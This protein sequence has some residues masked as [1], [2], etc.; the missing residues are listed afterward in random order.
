MSSL[1][2][3]TKNYERAVAALRRGDPVEAQAIALGAEEAITL[4]APAS[5]LAGH[6]LNVLGAVKY[7]LG[8]YKGCIDY[9]ER[10]SN[11]YN[12]LGMAEGEFAT[13][14][15]IASALRAMG[16]YREAAQRFEQLLASPIAAKQQL[17]KAQAT[18]NLGL[19][20]KG[21]GNTSAAIK[22]Y[23]E[24]LNEHRKNERLQEVVQVLINLAD[25]EAEAGRLESAPAIATEALQIARGLNNPVLIFQSLICQ[26]NTLGLQDRIKDAV[27]LFEEALEL[28][29][30]KLHNPHFEAL[31]KSSLASVWLE[32]GKYEQGHWTYAEARALFRTLG[33]RAAEAKCCTGIGL[34]HF[35]EGDY[36]AAIQYF[37]S[38]IQLFTG[39]DE[40]RKREAQIHL[41]DA[42]ARLNLPESEV[43][44]QEIL[45]Y[46][47]TEENLLDAAECHVRLMSRAAQRGD[48]ET[49][50]TH[51]EAADKIFSEHNQPTNQGYVLLVWAN[52]LYANQQHQEAVEMFEKAGKLFEYS[53]NDRLRAY[54]LNNVAMPLILM[55][56]MEQAYQKLETARSIAS[57]RDAFLMQRIEENL[58]LWH[59]RDGQPENALPHLRSAI[60]L[61]ERDFR[62]IRNEKWQ[63][64]FGSSQT[65]A[66]Q[67][68]CN[69]FYVTQDPLAML[70]Y[71]ERSRSR[72]FLES[73]LVRSPKELSPTDV[74]Q[75]PTLDF[76]QIKKSLTMPRVKHR[77]ALVEFYLT[78]NQL[79]TFVV[80]SD[81][82]ERGIADTQPITLSHPF[83][84][85]GLKETIHA[86]RTDFQHVA[87]RIQQGLPGCPAGSFQSTLDR[88]QQICNAVFSAELLG[89]LEGYDAL[90]LVPYGDLHYLPLHAAILN[91]PSGERLIDRFAI[92]YLPSASVLQFFPRE[93]RSASGPVPALLVGVDHTN[94]EACFAY[95]AEGLK[96]I[97]V[98]DASTT[99]L[100]RR[101]ATLAAIFDAISD[102]KVIHISSHGFFSRTD[103]IR[104]G[105]LLQ[106]NPWWLAERVDDNQV[107]SAQNLLDADIRL[108]AEIVTMSGCVTGESERRPG[109]ELIGLTRGL[110][111]AGTRSMIVALFPV[112]KNLTGI[113]PGTGRESP[114]SGF[115]R[116]WL[117]GEMTK[118][119]SFQQFIRELRAVAQH[120]YQ[121]FSFILVGDLY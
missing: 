103:A 18:N 41:G 40:R 10:A 94:E 39:T 73:L 104:S 23:Q 92:A 82:P 62:K 37:E 22:C 93:K 50:R 90:Y 110:L 77:T 42:Y 83:D 75:H 55:G 63:I 108:S 27:A 45:R 71:L 17:F 33:D 95:E 26:G 8:D 60:E 57:G 19:C 67:M 85:R 49:C 117:S 47:Y 21:L 54:A 96:G 76:F 56:H 35:M 13:N 5:A 16:A 79:F 99:V 89:Y 69:A 52:T 20:Y 81:Q 116:R 102:R 59:L 25:A 14:G 97:P 119:A 46:S 28:A 44:W 114:F 3:I 120:D 121:W 109:D 36:R 78:E 38:A 91:N 113:R 31:A 100:L 112:F 74:Q 15:N 66:Y 11:I 118:A 106:G 34:Y 1:Q 107:F 105:A 70:S 53:Q 64:A 29:L 87:Q 65:R 84:E 32:E 101:E 12:Q 4:L 80:R 98:F 2:L 58:G 9:S 68:I 7:T 61:L 43:I 115:Y 86:L 48:W 6:I 72:A 88:F 51:Y 111:Y 30:Y 24:A